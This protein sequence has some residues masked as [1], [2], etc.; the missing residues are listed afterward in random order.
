MQPLLRHARSLHRFGPA[1]RDHVSA[2][3]VAVS[4]AVPSLALLAAGHADLIIYAVFGALTGM[5][6]RSEPHQL[7]LRHQLHAAVVLVGGLSVG[8]VLSVHQIHSWAL[9]AV[10]AVLAVAGSLFADRVGLKPNGPF[11]GIFAL[12]ACAS[13]PTPV[14]GLV[15]VLVG[16]AS[17]AFSITVGFGGWVRN[18]RWERGAERGVPPLRG[19]RRRAAWIHAAR[20]F[21][22]VAAAGSIGVLSGS[23]HPHWAMA[24]AAVPLAGADLPSSVYRG[25]HRIVGTLL[26]LVV[27]ALVLFPWPLSPLR[28]FPGHETAAV[29]V[30]VIVLQ[31]TTE[32]FMTR[33]Y[34]LA[35]VFFTPVILL[36]TQ[37]AFPA[38]PRVLVTERAAETLLGACTGIAV[39][40]LIR[41][42]RPVRP[43]VAG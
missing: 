9:V 27:V 31:F 5:Y 3:R 24:S 34:G 6:G 35:M 21:T 20:Y 38:D 2:L 4:V 42:R 22:A 25:L 11:F 7:R 14:P 37:L 26:G 19:T 8:V 43:P 32:L 12:G 39:V 15:A 23:G 29:A 16:A 30:L 28:A 17:A 33:H 10:E 13:I 41:R 36:M 1:N 40:V 18:R